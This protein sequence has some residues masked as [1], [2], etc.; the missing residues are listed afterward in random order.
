M[1]AR[2]SCW[3]ASWSTTA[4]SERGLRALPRIRGRAYRT[5]IAAR[6]PRPR[7]ACA[8]GAGQRYRACLVRCGR[9]AGN[10]PDPARPV[11]ELGGGPPRDAARSRRCASEPAPSAP[12]AVTAVARVPACWSARW[13]SPPS[14]LYFP[15]R[16]PSACRLLTLAQA[17]LLRS[18]LIILGGATRANLAAS[19]PAEPF[20]NQSVRR[21]TGPAWQRFPPRAGTC[22]AC[23][24]CC[25]TPPL[26]RI[27]QA[28]P[29]TAAPSRPQ[30]SPWI[31]ALRHPRRCDS[32]LRPPTARRAV[33]RRLEIASERRTRPAHPP[34]PARAAALCPRRSA[35][36]APA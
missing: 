25:T 30:L 15:Q 28:A 24:C 11:A 6:P 31:E 1:P 26:L 9:R 17:R 2:C 13:S 36:R 29:E 8:A 33:H 22:R 32:N 5:R 4:A 12:P 18:G 34:R 27:T 19:A 23:A 7:R 35:P 20:F 3:N 14:F 21:R 10:Q 16:R